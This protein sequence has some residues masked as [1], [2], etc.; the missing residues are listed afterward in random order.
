MQVEALAEIKRNDCILGVDIANP[1]EVREYIF[2]YIIACLCYVRF[3][4]LL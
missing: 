3:Y 4:Y 2:V 1:V